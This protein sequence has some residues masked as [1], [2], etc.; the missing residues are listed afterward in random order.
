[1]AE[2]FYNNGNPYINHDG[3]KYSIGEMKIHFSSNGHTR[4]EIGF[5][6]HPDY[7]KKCQDIAKEFSNL[8]DEKE[9]NA[10]NARRSLDLIVE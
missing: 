7:Y 1:V 4:E 9:K 10:I 6:A 8:F 2:L 3:N 5:G